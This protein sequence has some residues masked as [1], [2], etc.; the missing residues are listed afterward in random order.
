M[1]TATQSATP[2]TEFTGHPRRWLILGILCLCLVLVVG[3][4]LWWDQASGQFQNVAAVNNSTKDIKVVNDQ[5]YFV[6]SISVPASMVPTGAITFKA[7]FSPGNNTGRYVL[8]NLA[9]GDKLRG[10]MR[11]TFYWQ[12]N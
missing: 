10:G 2:P 8:S 5:Q 9:E 7:E 12:D 6:E 4:Y 11:I 1:E 3:S